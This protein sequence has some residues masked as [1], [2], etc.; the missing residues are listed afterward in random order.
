MDPLA[1]LF[2]AYLQTAAGSFQEAYADHTD[3]HG[4]VERIVYQGNEIQFQHQ[5]WKVKQPSVCANLK[6]NATLYSACSVQAKSMFQD[7]CS[8]LS[9]STKLN[10]KGQHMNRM[11]CN[12]AS[13][14]KP[15]IAQI[16]NPSHKSPQQKKQQKCNLLILEAMQNPKPEIKRQRNAACADL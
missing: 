9:E 1:Q 16:S 10:S 4:R 7:L 8:R 2:A 3:L 5:L 11:Y 13:S 12:A 6:Q 15:M 14:Y